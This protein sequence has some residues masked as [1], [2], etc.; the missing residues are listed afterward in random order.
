MLKPLSEMNKK[1]LSLLRSLL[2]LLGAYLIPPCNALDYPSKPIKMI[3][4]FAP[5][6]G[7]DAIGR[8]IAKNLTEILG[9]PVV[10][11]NKAG[12]GGRLGVESGVKAEPDG[13]TILLISNS[14]AANPSLFKINFDP[15][16]D[17][18]PIGLIAKTPLLLAVRKDLPANSVVELIQYAKANPGKL[19]YASS[20]QGGISHLSTELFLKQAGIEMTHIPYKGT[21]PA[22]TDIVGGVTD[23][24]LSTTGAAL[25]YLQA[26]K[27]KVLAVTTPNRNVSEPHIPTISESGLP[28]YGVTVWYALVGPKNLPDD[29]VKKLNTALTTAVMDKKTLELFKTT[30]DTAAASTPDELKTVIFDEVNLWKKVVLDSKIKV[31]SN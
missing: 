22:I 27:I 21:A 2:L 14:Y 5:G 30:G 4:P 18:T 17:I 29:M 8:L 31:D 16:K 6:G 25:P 28:G 12:A 13:Y 10:V 19:S 26:K 15:N 24:F 1:L 20:G 9:Q 23:I 7:N 11:E 3:V